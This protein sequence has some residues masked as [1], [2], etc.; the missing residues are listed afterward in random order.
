MGWGGAGHRHAGARCLFVSPGMD[1]ED[2]LKKL[3]EELSKKEALL[4]EKNQRIEQLERDKQ[5]RKALGDANPGAASAGTA[6][7]LGASASGAPAAA[8]AVSRTPT[9]PRSWTAAAPGTPDHRLPA[10]ARSSPGWRRHNPGRRRPTERGARGARVPSSRA[11]RAA[12][13][14]AGRP[15]RQARPRAATPHTRARCTSDL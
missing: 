10:A 9:R 2:Q 13:P 6:A 15:L 7:S 3:Q 12:A 14:A 4:A 5:E 1:R 11:Q 8:A